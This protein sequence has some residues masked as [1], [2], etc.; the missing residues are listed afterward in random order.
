MQ[1]LSLN[2]FRELKY[3]RD[4]LTFHLHLLFRIRGPS[5]Y[6]H[7]AQSNMLFIWHALA[8][9]VILAI[10]RM[11]I[12]HRQNISKCIHQYAVAAVLS[13]RHICLALAPDAILAIQMQIALNCDAHPSVA[14][15][16]SA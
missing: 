16:F 1:E 13:M 14:M 6:A 9:D 15:M 11:P 10:L 4:G 12:V 5:P 2:Q 3:Q 7:A 8:V